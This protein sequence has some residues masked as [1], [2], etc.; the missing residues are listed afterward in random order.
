VSSFGFGKD[1]RIRATREHR[2]H[3][4]RSRT[5]RTRHFLVAWAPSRTDHSRIGLTVSKKV[6]NAPERARSKRLLREWFR[7][8]RHELVFA[9]DLVVIANPSVPS[10]SLGDVER[11]LAELVR[12][13]SRQARP[14]GERP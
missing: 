6:G 4:A 7:L 10:L 3:R 2:Q 9:W 14:R 1:L 13:L 8:H 5:F 11:D 12:Y